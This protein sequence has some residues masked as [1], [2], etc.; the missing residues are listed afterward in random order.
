MK[1]RI[2][3][4]DNIIDLI[5]NELKIVENHTINIL[6]TSY[7]LSGHSIKHKIKQ[8]WKVNKYKQYNIEAYLYIEIYLGAK[9][10]FIDIVDGICMTKQLT[11]DILKKI[12]SKKYIARVLKTSC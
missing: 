12:P 4:K 2:N 3:T 11:K 9:H 8:G 7:I 10:Y 5:C 6:N 1:N